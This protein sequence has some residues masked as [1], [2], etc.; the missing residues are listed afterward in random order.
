[1]V[2]KHDGWRQPLAR[3]DTAV[4]ALKASGGAGVDEALAAVADLRRVLEAWEEA[5]AAR[6]SDVGSMVIIGHLAAAVAHEINNLLFVIRGSAE[7]ARLNLGDGDPMQARLRSIDEAVDRAKD[8]TAMVL[9]AARSAG[10]G[11]PP[12]PLHPVVKE[13]VKLARASLG[14]NV[15][16]R[17]N[18]TASAPAIV[19]D[20]IKAY[21]LVMSLLDCAATTLTE[22]GGLLSVTLNVTD[23]E[24][25]DRSGPGIAG[26]CLLLAVAWAVGEDAE[27]L[28]NRASDRGGDR[29]E[30]LPRGADLPGNAV[31]IVHGLGGQITGYT[32]GDGG[33]CIEVLLPL[34]PPPVVV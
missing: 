9:Y 14:D 5:S 17:Q 27:D 24:G 6:G 33:L 3:V 11:P 12:I 32:V 26:S 28:I 18:V 34:S 19:V 7:L 30:E 16:V 1:M 23:I 25:G 29:T 8:L 4:A 21:Q 31:E 22:G 2:S 15:K 13:G 20:P 10:G